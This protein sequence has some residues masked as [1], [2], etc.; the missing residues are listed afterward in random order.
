MATKT[1][2]KT[3]RNE[4]LRRIRCLMYLS[5]IAFI[6]G[7]SV[8]TITY[9]QSNNAVQ[10][11]TNVLCNIITSI[12]QILSI[13]ALMLFILGG[14]LYAFAHFLPAAGNFRGN[15]QSWGMGMLMGGIIA[16]ILYT[17]A[18]FIVNQIILVNS[19]SQ[20]TNAGNTSQVIAPVLS[21]GTC[22]GVGSGTSISST[23]PDTTPDCGEDCG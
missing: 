17:L 6:F 3:R 8:L 12:S 14:T 18:P 23:N 2:R 11:V 21:G 7:G 22:T 15:M 19:Q 4:T 13:L 10:S 16:L 5:L 9:A 20:G 1:N